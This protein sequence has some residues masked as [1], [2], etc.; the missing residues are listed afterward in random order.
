MSKTDYDVT[1]TKINTNTEK[2]D[3]TEK[4]ETTEKKSELK[5]GDGKSKVRVMIGGKKVIIAT[6]DIDGAKHSHVSGRDFTDKEI[7]DFKS[8]K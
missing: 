3:T 2:A 4:V 1:N 6:K 8:A 7:K 5:M